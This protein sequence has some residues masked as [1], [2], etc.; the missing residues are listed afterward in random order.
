MKYNHIIIDTHN[1]FF[2]M[3]HGLKHKYQSQEKLYEETTKK[4]LD[5]VLKFESSLISEGTIWCLF[6][7][8]DS[9]ANIRC[10]LSDDYKYNRKDMPDLFYRYVE[11]L[12]S[13]LLSY[14][15][16]INIVYI[17]RLE[18][19]DLVKPIV[20][21]EIN[22]EESVLMVS[23]DLDWARMVNYQERRI[24]LYNYE[25]II[26]SNLF[27]SKYGFYPSVNR[28]TL[29]KTIE[30]DS[31]DNINKGLPYLKEG[32]LFYILDNYH[33]ALDLIT[34]GVSDKTLSEATRRRVSNRSN[35]LRI[36][37]NLV[38]FIDLQEFGIKSIKDHIYYGRFKKNTLRKYYKMLDYK[39]LTRDSRYKDEATKTGSFFQEQILE[40]R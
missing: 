22:K 11:I 26:D 13:M 7:N 4:S 21:L 31:S 38:T 30:G 17:E 9:K 2:R 28:I 32:E 5:K 24:Y 34:R 1:L 36:N 15:D 23:S 19:D 16:N 35:E 18:A 40:R 27:F 33:D 20:D 14:Q 39:Y 37:W 6:D 12:K 8:H 3:Y 25:D 29:Y 10:E